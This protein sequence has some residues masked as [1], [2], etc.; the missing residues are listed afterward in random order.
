MRQPSVN[1]PYIAKQLS[2]DAAGSRPNEVMTPIAA[3]LTEAERRNIGVHFAALPAPATPLR[4]TNAQ[5]IRQ[6][7][8]IATVGSPERGVQ[9]CSN[10]HGPNGSGMPPAV[11]YHAGCPATAVA[12]AGLH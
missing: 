5:L 3:Q 11:P 4:D 12:P 9:S 8:A 10:C 1:G 7:E 2:N 6:G